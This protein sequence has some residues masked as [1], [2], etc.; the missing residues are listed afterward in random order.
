MKCLTSGMLQSAYK[1]A[2]IPLV[3]GEMLLRTPFSTAKCRIFCTG[4]IA[5]NEEHRRNGAP[6]PEAP[7]MVNQ[8]AWNSV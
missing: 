8:P 1:E 7:L 4:S 5:K 3:L 2:L 6:M